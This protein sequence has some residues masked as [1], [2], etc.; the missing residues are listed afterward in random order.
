MRSV[1][2]VVLDVLG[3]DR[4]Q[5]RRPRIISQSRHSRW[6]LETQHSHRAF[7]FGA[8]YRCVD[9]LQAFGS[10]DGIEGGWKVAVERRG[11]RIFNEDIDPR[12]PAV[13][14]TRHTKRKH[15]GGARATV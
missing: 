7:A 2:V 13:C 8:P 4:L 5:C 10:K 9:G 6:T 15:Q 3:Q 14:S 11:P 12:E 1:P